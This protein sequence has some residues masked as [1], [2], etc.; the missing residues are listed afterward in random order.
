MVPDNGIPDGRA[1]AR[2]RVAGWPYALKITDLDLEFDLL[3]RRSNPERVSR[4]LP[5]TGA[6]G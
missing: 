4:L 2:G 6:T 1:G 3:F 5:W